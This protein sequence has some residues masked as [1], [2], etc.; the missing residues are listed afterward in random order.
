MPTLLEL[1]QNKKD[2]VPQPG[3]NVPVE[4]KTIL[5]PD[6]GS[7]F[8]VDNKQSLDFIKAIPKIYGTDVVRITTET[9]P[10][11]TKVA[12][13]KA[14]GAV[15]GAIGGAFGSFGKIVGSKIAGVMADFH[16]QF[17]D[18]FLDGTNED[19]S[20]VFNKYAELYRSDYA[21]GKYYN[22]G[23]KNSKSKLGNFLQSNKTPGQIKDALIPAAKSLVVG[24]A[25]GG[26]KKLFGGKKKKSNTD[27]AKKKSTPVPFFPSTFVINSNTTLG[28]NDSVA[29]FQEQQ[30]RSSLFPYS[31]G[32]DLYTT[33]TVGKDEAMASKR[34]DDLA[35]LVTLYTNH[36][37][38]NLSVNNDRDT[39]MLY[40]NTSYYSPLMW[41]GTD[42]DPFARTGIYDKDVLRIFDINAPSDWTAY[43]TIR[44]FENAKPNWGNLIPTSSTL[45]YGT[46][47][48]NLYSQPNTKDNV[49]NTIEYIHSNGLPN[50]VRYNTTA[51]LASANIDKI[52]KNDNTFVSGSVQSQNKVS[53]FI[54]PYI[55]E[56]RDI[57]NPTNTTQNDRIKFKIGDTILLATLTG[58]TDNTTPSWTDVKAVG[59]GFKFYLF[60]SWEREISFKLQLYAENEKELDWI[61]QKANKI[62][63]LTLPKNGGSKGVFGRVI[64]LVI[65]DVIDAQ[66]GFLTACNTSI[67]DN[68][69]WEITDGKQKPFVFEMDITYKAITNDS[70]YKHY[71]TIA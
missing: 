27:P 42:K 37:D 52:L 20:L 70:T 28:Y 69:P 66:Y 22:G 19:N 38:A 26:L 45:I 23:I 60:D 57:L 13:K 63:E 53:K 48:A 49:E 35:D 71:K 58:L 55:I 8:S 62:K 39:F 54:N 30:S 43:P 21:Y 51:S 36:Y 32:K 24:L 1:L 17:P 34:N 67:L 3:N 56:K 7:Q 25:I 61:W 15:G 6:P 2:I 65:G 11:E 4:P 12:I 31:F 50:V 9:D 64:P 16:P 29:F 10:H 5:K 44:D 68:S 14:A 59:S 47:G 46:T 40:A 41:Q 33:H 18:D